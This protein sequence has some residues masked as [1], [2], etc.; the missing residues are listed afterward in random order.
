MGLNLKRLGL[1]DLSD[2]GHRGLRIQDWGRSEPPH[3]W[4]DPTG[5]GAALLLEV[6]AGSHEEQHGNREQEVH[7]RGQQGG[8]PPLGHLRRRRCALG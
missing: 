1:G 8:P 3:R 4:G 7:T 5:E 6:A 2:S